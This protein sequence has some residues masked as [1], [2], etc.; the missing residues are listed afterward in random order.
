MS[1]SPRT[2]NRCHQ[3]AH[4]VDKTYQQLGLKI[5]ILVSLREEQILVL[6]DLC[7]PATTKLEANQRGLFNSSQLISPSSAHL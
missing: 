2:N 3:P 7:A 4:A 1:W 5:K 6:G